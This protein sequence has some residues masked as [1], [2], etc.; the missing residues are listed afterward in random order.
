MSET[1][2]D[3]AVRTVAACYLFLS[4]KAPRR[5]TQ[6]G[7]VFLTLFIATIAM[8]Q[9]NPSVPFLIKMY[10][11]ETDLSPGGVSV[12][13]CALVLPNGQLRLEVKKQQL[14]NPTATFSV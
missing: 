10:E 4:T 5:A 6:N 1:V 12:H 14:P 11:L 8:G 13:N 9:Q 7:F 2:K 3:R